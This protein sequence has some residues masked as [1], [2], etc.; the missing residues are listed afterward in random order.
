MSSTTTGTFFLEALPRD[1]NISKTST[2]IT[3]GSLSGINFEPT[4]PDAIVAAS[5]LAD[6]EVPDGGYGWVVIA[7]CSA[8]TFWFV[9]TTYSWGIIQAALVERNLSSPSTISFVGSLTCASISI[10]ALV[11][12]RTIRKLGA[13]MTALI[14]VGCLGLGEILSGFSTRNVVSTITPQYFNKKRGV[15]NGIVYAGGGLGGTVISFAVNGLLSSLGPEWTFRILGL[16][17][18]ATGFPAAWLIKERLPITTATFIEWSLFKNVQFT[19]LFFAGAI[20]TFPLFVPPFFL[21]LYSASLGLSPSAGAGLVAGFNFSSAV[22]RLCCGFLCDFMGPVNTLLLSLF[23]SALSMLAIWPVSNSLGPLIVFVIIN[24]AANGGFFSCMPTVVGSV[25]GSRRVGVAMG[26]IVTG[27]G[28]GYLMGAPI[29]GYLLAAY[30]GPHS[31]LKAYHP[32][33]IYAGSMALGAALL[34]LVLKLRTS[35][36]PF[37]KL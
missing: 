10:L 29:A 3:E 30:G 20:A 36:S 13:R 11:N 14:G 24:G 9:G 25:F 2:P 18:L 37:K 17:T 1:P 6:A 26:M 28:G 12:A 5:R 8:L 33:M 7:A 23:L 34:V 35:K 15:A 16:V 21:P 4:N 31:T 22:G 27:W 32:A 19:T